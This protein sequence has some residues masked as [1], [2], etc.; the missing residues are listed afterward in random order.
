M[1]EE[2]IEEIKEAVRQIIREI[3][4]VGKEPPPQV[5]E[6]LLRVI[7][8]FS[9]EIDQL[10]SQQREEEATLKEQEE[11]AQA[12]AEQAQV[13]SEL[14]PTVEAPKVTGEPVPPLQPAPYPSSN[15]NAFKYEPKKGRLFVKFQDKF[16]QTNG[17]VYVYEGVPAYIVNVFARGAV[18]PKTSGKN[19]WHS[20]RKG[21]T[22]SLGA[23]MFALI[24]SGAFP[25]SRVQ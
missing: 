2:R 6:L 18:A 23:A 13:A 19:K 15:I 5:Q 10:R 20:W 3:I 12:E 7:E 22:P 9:N 25:Y 1:I 11:L 24:K 4:S 8:K 21:V 16:P 17:P 14:G